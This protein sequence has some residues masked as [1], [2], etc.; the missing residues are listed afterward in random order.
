M[1]VYMRQVLRGYAVLLETKRDDRRCIVLKCATNWILRN[2]HILIVCDNILLVL[3]LVAVERFY[4]R[5]SSLLPPTQRI[6]LLWNVPKPAYNNGIDV[7]HCSSI[8]A[9]ECFTFGAGHG[10]SCGVKNYI[11]LRVSCRQSAPAAHHKTRE[12]D[13][14]PPSIFRE[15]SELLRRLPDL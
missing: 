2:T 15:P 7:A 6:Q 3:L 5:I 13:G 11:G 12:R 8:V 9:F 4:C 10:T 1:P 14:P